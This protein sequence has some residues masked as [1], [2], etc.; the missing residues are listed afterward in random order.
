MSLNLLS[1]SEGLLA[2]LL[3]AF[4][5]EQKQCILLALIFYR[6]IAHMLKLRAQMSMMQIQRHGLKL[7]L[8]KILKLLPKEIEPMLM[9][10]RTEK[11]R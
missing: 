2:I 1:A 7:S 6:G 4:E 5:F 3:V 8:L 10:I 9:T 11:N